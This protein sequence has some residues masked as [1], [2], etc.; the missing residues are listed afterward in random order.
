MNELL[1]KIVLASQS[2]LDQFHDLRLNVRGSGVVLDSAFALNLF[3]RSEGVY[4]A[5]H[6]LGILAHPLSPIYRISSRTAGRLQGRENTAD[7]SEYAIP[8]NGPVGQVPIY[9][10]D[11]FKLERMGVDRTGVDIRVYYH[12]NINIEQVEGSAL[13]NLHLEPTI[14]TN[15]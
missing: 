6:H 3:S 4:K 1:E 5:V 2:S 13:R 8:M 14:V 7:L 11:R 10:A 15:P 9:L 12:G